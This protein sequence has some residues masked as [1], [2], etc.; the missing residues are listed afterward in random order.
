MT[1]SNRSFLESPREVINVARESSSHQSA[2]IYPSA[3]HIGRFERVFSVGST[4]SLL[5]PGL[6][7][8]FTGLFDV[9]GKGKAVSSTKRARMLEKRSQF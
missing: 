4:I 3:L 1:G 5:S 8:I 7:L 2:S 6:K 9:G